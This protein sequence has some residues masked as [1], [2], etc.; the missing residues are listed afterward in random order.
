MSE[1]AVP[2]APVKAAPPAP[3][4]LP[5]EKPSW[6]GPCVY[7]YRLE[8][9]K[10][11]TSIESI[12]GPANKEFVTLGRL[13]LCDILMEHPS[14]S[15]Y[16]AIIQFD[17]DGDA[18]LYDLDSAHGTRLNKNA[19]PAREYVQLKP[20]DQI[21]F[22]ESTRLC[23]F[24]SEKP[25]DPE[26][27]ALERRKIALKQ[28]IAKQRGESV[29]TQEDNEGISWGFTED[30][31]EMPEEE[32]GDEKEADATEIEANLDK[33]G[34]ASLLNVEAEKMA[35][36]DAMAKEKKVMLD[37]KLLEEKIEEKK[38]MGTE[39]KEEDD[40]DLDA[41]MSKLA[42]KPLQGDKSLF[43]LQRELTQLKKVIN[44]G[45]KI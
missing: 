45:K 6:S 42:K 39:K 25:Y 3:P 40:E 15:R 26:E 12:K 21:R 29:P 20:G 8:V 34:D 17:Q 28:R 5:Y 13:P 7:N 31:E 23:I 22:G 1:F 30:A 43:V 38:R 44:T 10:N 24:D 35:F 19:V 14:I 4:P 18:Y 41:F 16:H 36:E 27:E 33:S 32:E 11:G 2:E 9:L 37:I